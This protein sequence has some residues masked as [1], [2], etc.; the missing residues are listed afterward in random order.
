MER[1]TDFIPHAQNDCTA[2]MEIFQEGLS[3]HAA[4]LG[5][6]PA[7]VT[8]V[9]ADVAARARDCSADDA[10][11]TAYRAST[12]R[13]RTADR[14]AKAT[15]RA[16][17]KRAKASATY[18]EEIGRALGIIGPTTDF[19]PLTA[20][21][22]LTATINGNLVIIGFDKPYG[23]DGA[24]IYSRRT[25]ETDFTLLAYDTESPYHD[26]RLNRHGNVAEVREYYAIFFDDEQEIGLRSDV[27][28][29]SVDFP[30]APPP[31]A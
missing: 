8:N 26:S 23:V 3:T 2:F 6:P 28:S 30:Q 18:T 25:G 15:V 29:I 11:R 31:V 1:Q 14:K 5:L 10:A 16:V 19:D 9:T 24:K 27:V 21:P 22:F 17:A 12:A 20:K 13:K 4:A 7:D